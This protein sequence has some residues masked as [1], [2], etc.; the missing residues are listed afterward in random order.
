MSVMRRSADRLALRMLAQ[1]D[2]HRLHV[3][4]HEA[5]RRKAAERART[6]LGLGGGYNGFW[7]RWTWSVDDVTTNKPRA[8]GWALT[9]WSFRRRR[10]AAYL[11]EL[12]RL[13]ADGRAE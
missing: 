4:L 5:L 9:E 8:T 11:R 1:P 12:D 10:Y 13:T 7:R 3:E 6:R 2:G